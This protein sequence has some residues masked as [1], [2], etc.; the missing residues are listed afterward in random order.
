MARSHL[1]LVAGGKQYASPQA[2]EGMDPDRGTP[3]P[4]LL[5]E[6]A[7]RFEDGALERY[8]AKKMGV[9][10]GFIEAAIRREFRRVRAENR[11]LRAENGSL[12]RD[13]LRRAA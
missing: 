10:R 12:K 7:H 1:A 3:V 5:A 8:L 11:E 2:P 6:I 4:S 9:Q 13:A